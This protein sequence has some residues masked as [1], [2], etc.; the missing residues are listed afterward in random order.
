MV[1]RVSVDVTVAFED[2]NSKLADIV[3]EVYIRVDKKAFATA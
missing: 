1:V 3:S 2:V